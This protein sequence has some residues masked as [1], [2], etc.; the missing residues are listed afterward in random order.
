MSYFHIKDLFLTFRLI[1]RSCGHWRKTI[2]YTT[3]K[4]FLLHFFLSY[5]NNFPKPSL[6]CFLV[7]CLCLSV[8]SFDSLFVCFF[9]S[10]SVWMSVSLS[11]CLYECLSLCRCFMN[12]LTYFFN[13]CLWPD[14]P[15][16][17]NGYIKQHI[18]VVWIWTP[19]QRSA[20][21]W[22]R[23]G[24]ILLKWS[25]A[26]FPKISAGSVKRYRRKLHKIIRFSMNFFTKLHL[27]LK[28]KHLNVTGIQTK[29]VLQSVV[30][31]GIFCSD[32][33]FFSK[34]AKKLIMTDKR[35]K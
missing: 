25:I 21:T 19:I 29:K 26:L 4:L 31:Y 8:C 7:L 34:E 11:R 1:I 17:D 23:T 15:A 27:E 2:N 14:R 12:S 3:K 16:K 5:R 6:A 32:M 13:K 30:I 20:K 9:V 22:S 33:Y 35:T 24:F 10:M 28:V 18:Q